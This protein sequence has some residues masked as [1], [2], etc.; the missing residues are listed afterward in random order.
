MAR[1]P[2]ARA[3]SC[4]ARSTQA[5]TIETVGKRQQGFLVLT[6]R[7]IFFGT[8]LLLSFV[9]LSDAPAGA[10]SAQAAPRYAE[11]MRRELEALGLEPSCS[12]KPK[13]R[14]ECVYAGRALADG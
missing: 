4:C 5:G 9:L 2:T 6:A 10:Q 11:P 7:P 1:N 13:L 3:P 8:A 14:Y 12:P